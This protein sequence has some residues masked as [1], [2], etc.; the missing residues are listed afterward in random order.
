MDFKPH[1]LEYEIP[2]NIKAGRSFLGLSLKGWIYFVSTS[3]F[4]G[5]LGYLGI[6]LT[7]AVLHLNST[8]T[9]ILQVG[10]V[11]FLGALSYMSFEMD[12]RTGEMKI[13][14]LLD[15]LGWMFSEKVIDPEWGDDGY[16]KIL[17][18]EES[19]RKEEQWDIQEI[20]ESLE[21]LRTN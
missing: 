20:I 4:S 6:D 13:E 7:S 5:V 19:E 11:L 14:F 8:T 9:L 3:I 15:R 18:D 10:A 16:G 12:E 2:R 1:D 17:V 21:R